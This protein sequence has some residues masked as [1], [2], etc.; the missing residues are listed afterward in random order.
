MEVDGELPPK[1][2]MPTTEEHVKA[3]YAWYAKIQPAVESRLLTAPS[4][5]RSQSC[6]PRRLPAF[7]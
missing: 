7:R 4:P 3:V 1:P 5:R 6:P 2:P